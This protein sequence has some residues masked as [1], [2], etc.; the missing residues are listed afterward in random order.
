MTGTLAE[1]YQLGEELG[2]GAM[3]EVWAATRRGDGQAVAVK[4][5]LADHLKRADLVARFAREQSVLFG[6][7]HPNVVR[8]L[9]SGEETGRPWFV[10]ERLGETLQQ[11]VVGRGPFA[12]D[13]VKALAEEIG[14]GLEAL[15]AQQV[16]HR[17][18]KPSN[19]LY[20]A[21]GRLRVADLGIAARPADPRIT[22]DQAVLGSVRYMA[23]EQR[24]DA[25]RV[26]TRADVYS[27]AATLRYAL[28]GKVLR[29]LW[30]DP[31]GAFDGLPETWVPL[32]RSALA[33]EVDRRPASIAAFL[34]QLR[35]T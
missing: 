14:A 29:D 9:D 25:H 28:T 32:L 1:R 22:A 21:D 13:A 16:V 17:D 11:R 23:P 34:E 10:M 15:H 3:A 5:M 19:L 8:V 18:V 20:G 6:L 30:R 7:T 24:F 12:P 26:D 33:W 27:L 4:W 2:R 31:V 35:A